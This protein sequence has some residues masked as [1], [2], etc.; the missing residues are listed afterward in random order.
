MAEHRIEELDP[1]FAQPTAEQGLH[2][3]DVRAFAAGRPLEG[4]GWSD[5]G[6]PFARLPARA[7]GTVRDPVWSLAQHSAGLCVRFITDAIHISARWSLWD[8]TLAMNHMAASGVSGIDLYI[9]DTTRPRHRRYHWIGVGRPTQKDANTAALVEELAEGEHELILYLPLYNGVESVEIGV[10]EGSV[11]R[12]V[13]RDEKPIVMYGTSILQGACASRPG[14]AYPALIG[15]MLDHPV[16]NLGFSGNA[17]AEPEMA[18]LLAELDPCIYVLDY[19]PNNPPQRIAER[20]EPFIRTLRKA[21]PHTPIV[22]VENIIY[23]KHLYVPSAAMNTRHRN[24]Q[25]RAAIERLRAAGDRH[26][27]YVPCDNLLGDDGEATVDGTHATD[28]GFVR[29][30]ATIG[31]VVESLL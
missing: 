15:R 5:V 16:I 2:W 10:P 29:M 24:A 21:H 22:A 28:V 30:A 12:A 17:Q 26:L 25:F 20:T 9:R 1:N 13:R 31:P 4:Q 11:V 23:Q 6:R 14:M 27:Y 3:Y 7:E 19:N 8:A 18:E